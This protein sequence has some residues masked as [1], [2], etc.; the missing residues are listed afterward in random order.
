MDGAW[1]QLPGP[2]IFADAVVEEFRAGRSAL[3]ALPEHLPLGLRDAVG[4]RVRANDLWLWR[5]LDA[6]EMACAS[7]TEIA[8]QLHGQFAPVAAGEPCSA[9]TLARSAGFSGVI[10]WVER[11]DAAAWSP[12]FSFLKQY[13]HACH[14]RSAADRGLFCVPLPAGVAAPA[15]DVTLSVRRWEGTVG[16][17]DMVLYLDRLLEPRLRQPLHRQLALAVAA[18]LAGTDPCLARTLAGLELRELL[19]PYD[20]LH[21]FAAGRGWPG[22]GQAANASDGRGDTRDGTPFVHAA[23]ALASGDKREVTRRIWRAEVG[24]LYP[25]IEERRL[26]LLPRVRSL[27]RLPVET[28]YGT[29]AEAEDLE[30]GQLLYFLRGRSVRPALWRLLNLL[31]DMRHMLAHLHPVPVGHLF[32]DELLQDVNDL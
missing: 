14:G 30:V 19:S 5:T 26:Q 3:L 21:E 17:L 7:P 9:D 6:A 8:E 10:A 32:A 29:V 1:W 31:A 23:F 20:V 16:R 27:L 15:Q 4:D 13:Q 25:F 24:V 18:E 28:T 11:L 12:W 22:T 2:G